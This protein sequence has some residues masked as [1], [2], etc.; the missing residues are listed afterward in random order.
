MNSLCL[1]I[2]ASLDP[3][4]WICYTLIGARTT[5]C[6]NLD[7]PLSSS[8]TEALV[9]PSDFG[10]TALELRTLSSAGGIVFQQK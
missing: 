4:D 7:H 5:N 8:E 10:H 6:H 1:K 9:R 2:D 3:T